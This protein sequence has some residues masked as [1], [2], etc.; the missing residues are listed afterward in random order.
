MRTLSNRQFAHLLVVALLAP[1]SLGLA[2]CAGEERFRLREPA[3]ASVI[4]SPQPYTQSHAAE[5]ARLIGQ[6]RHTLDIAMYSFSDAAIFDALEAA[7]ARGVEIR[8]LWRGGNDDRKLS[9]SALDSSTSGQLEH[10]GINVRYVNKIMH[11][12]LMIVDG[13][14]DVLERAQTATLVTGSA[15]WSYGGATIYDENTLFFT[16]HPALAIDYQREF[17]LMWNHSR[18]VVVDADLPHEPSTADLSDEGIWAAPGED[19]WFTSDN[20]RIEEGSTTFRID[21]TSTK[22]ADRIVVAIEGATRSIHIASGHLR[23]RPVAE[24][25][26]AARQAHPELDIRVYLDQQEYFGEFGDQA[27]QDAVDD[28][29]A[30]ATTDIQLFRCENGDFLWGKRVGEAG[31]DVRYKVY[32][33]RWDYSYAVQMHDKY[34]LID[35]D[36]MISGS[37]NL[38]M[39]SEQ[40]SF[41]NTVHLSGPDFAGLVDQ[42]EANFE[43]LWQTGREDEDLLPDLRA[44]VTRG[45]TFPIVFPSM[46]LTWQEYTD[47]RLLIR[48]NCPAINTAPFRNDPSAHRTCS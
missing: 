14:R 47:L 6:A 48:A 18:D 30:D 7:R 9:G 10:I 31:V 46:A 1:P 2:S 29:L 40:G 38:S 28:C 25:L 23:L 24:A 3:E 20:F 37:Y 12:K 36:E 22:V 39:N 21:G 27:Q 34:I 43:T 19:A 33:Y 45:T 32:S 16:G 44:Q 8:F 35:G 42:Y 13:P 4:F 15:N 17:D 26:I 41:E 5:V 11:H